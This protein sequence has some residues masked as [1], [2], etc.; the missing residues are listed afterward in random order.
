MKVFCRDIIFLGRDRVGQG[1]EK[2]FRDRAI[3][4]RDIVGHAMKFLCHDRGFLGRDKASHDI[5][6]AMRARKAMPGTHDKP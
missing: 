4:C 3:L 1:K 6:E 2:F 5:D